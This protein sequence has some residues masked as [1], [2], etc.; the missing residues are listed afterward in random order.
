M[1][2]EYEFKEITV[3]YGYSDEKK[4]RYYTFLGKEVCEQAS[5][6]NSDRITF[7]T[8]YQLENEMYIIH[9]QLQSLWKGELDCWCW[10]EALPH[11][12]LM[13]SGVLGDVPEPHQFSKEE[14]MEL[15]PQAKM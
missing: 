3:R 15:F 4:G 2:N 9:K 12:H 7:Y 8:V 1:N 13:G 6:M 5:G 11:K 14:I 10:Y